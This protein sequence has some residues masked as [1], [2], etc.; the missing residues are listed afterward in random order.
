MK[1]SLN[2]GSTFIPVRSSETKNSIMFM[3]G[4]QAG[5][6]PN[7]KNGRRSSKLP[8]NVKKSASNDGILE[9]AGHEDTDPS[10]GDRND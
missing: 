7:L 4:D 10:V 3:G 5:K 2:R 1:Q 8:L 9:E 6:A